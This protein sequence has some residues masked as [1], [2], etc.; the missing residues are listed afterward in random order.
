[1]LKIMHRYIAGMILLFIA[2][3]FLNHL[4]GIFSLDGHLKFMEWIRP[5]YRNRLVEPVL[6]SALFAQLLLGLI[7]AIRSRGK[8]WGLHGKL[9]VISGC[10]LIFF[11]VNHT[12]AT[13]FSR[14]T[15]QLDTNFYFA[16]AGLHF[17]Q[18]YLFFVPYYF[19]GVLALFTH[20]GCALQSILVRRGV[21]MANRYFTLTLTGGA[22]FAALVVMSLAGLFYPVE[23][24]EEYFA[25][26]KRGQ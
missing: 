25:V 19:F 12:S 24:P 26:Y 5:F 2:L 20:V 17:G 7:L 9:Q 6:L 21:A 13:V 10:Y 8:G 15:M 11:L 1:M 22:I 4:V 18:M 14:S 3:H 23:M 16:A